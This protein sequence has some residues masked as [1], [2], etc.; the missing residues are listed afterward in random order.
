MFRKFLLTLLALMLAAL[1]AFAEDAPV[2]SEDVLLLQRANNAL[3]ERYG[4]TIPTLGLFDATLAR[5]GDTAFVTYVSGGSIPESLTGEYHVVITG[6]A[7]QAYWTHDDVDPTLWQSGDL[8][9]PAWGV[10]QLTLYLA[11]SPYTR[12]DFS[13]P[14]VT[15][16]STREEV[17][18][19][20]RGEAE[21]AK[22]L[23]IAAVQA[24]YGLTDEETAKLS[25]VIDMV[26][27]IRYPDGHGEWEVMLLND[28]I[29]DPIA[30]YV[31]LDTET[32]MILK[33]TVSSGGVG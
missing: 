18:K 33:I 23:A 11:E 14:Y 6:D 10:K 30:Y 25:W 2:L 24:M 32:G 3:I 28:D 29:L 22:V 9:G 4:L 20:N 8:T 1:P 26:Q 31:T 21:Q 19:E 12:D 5:C 16:A 15:V 17:N 27:H 13:A 7:V